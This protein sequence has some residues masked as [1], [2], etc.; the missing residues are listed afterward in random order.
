LELLKKTKKNEIDISNMP[1]HLGFIMDG[2]RRWAKEK[3][4]PTLEGH[5]RGFDRVIDLIEGALDLNIPHITVYAFSTENWDRSKEEID[6]LMSLFRKMFQK[7]TKEFSKKGVKIKVAGRLSD[8]PEDVQSSALKAIEDTKNNNRLT[9]N[10][11]FSYGGRAEIIDVVKKI[12]ADKLSVDSIT[13]EKF[14]EYLYEAGQPDPDM[15]VRTSGEKRL[16]GFM[17]WQ[18][19]Y[20]ELYFIDKHWPDFDKATLVDVVDEYQKRERRFGK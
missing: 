6:Y 1:R 20:S 13:E 7:A 11:A 18:S 14:A 12:I 16:S 5:R 9:L 17:L 4:L 2:N 3:G 10:I 19:S 15:I 8:F